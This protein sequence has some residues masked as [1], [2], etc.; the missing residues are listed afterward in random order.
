[1]KRESQDLL[2]LVDHLAQ[3][4]QEDEKHESGRKQV[5]Q[6]ADNNMA[7]RRLDISRQDSS[8]QGRGNWQWQDW[9]I[10]RIEG[11]LNGCLFRAT[12]PAG[13]VAVKFTTRDKRD[14]A[15]R[16]WAALEFLA[17][18]AAD[19]AP[20]PLLLDRDRYANQVIVQTWLAGESS[21]SIPVD[22]AAWVSLSQHLLTIH[23]LPKSPDHPAIRP[24]VL[25]VTSPAEALQAICFQHS[26]LQRAEWPN[27]VNEL[28]AQVLS[29]GWPRWPQP[30]LR[31][32]RSDPNIRNFIRR[33]NAWASVDWEYS[34]WGDPA[35]KIADFLVHGAHSEWPRQQTRRLAEIYGACSN[36][37]AIPERIAVYETLM[38]VWWTLRLGRIL[39]EA[40]S[41]RDKRLVT[42]SQSWL[43][44][45]QRLQ[46][47]YQNLAEAALANCKAVL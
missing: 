9:S 32:C 5:G 20:L 21:A 38:L 14:R 29:I 39:P 35:F 3:A 13:D 36:D 10:V 17:E 4:L 23:S 46:E 25:Y 22:D 43:V 40:R 24:V 45:R 11:G 1:M 44:D 18:N 26:R 33:A 15:G 7:A 34:G 6:L 8:F 42:F 27:A 12:G 28:I 31:F 30:S 16:E 47:R 37:T 41:G 19:L 2:P